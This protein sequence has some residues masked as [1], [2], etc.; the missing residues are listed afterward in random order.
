[1]S[2]PSRTICLLYAERELDGSALRETEAHLVDCRACRARVVALREES[3]LL[4]DVLRSER[5]RARADAAAAAP[6]PGVALGVPLAIAAVPRPAAVASAL[7]DVRL[8]GALDLLNP[9]RLKERST[10]PSI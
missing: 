8:P 7:L 9:R 6:E 3:T 1:M 4:G 10:W 2:C 5:E